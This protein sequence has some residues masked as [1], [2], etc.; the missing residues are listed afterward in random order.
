[1]QRKGYTK[2]VIRRTLRDA[3][4]AGIFTE[5]NIVVGVPGETNADAGEAIGFLLALKPY[6]RRV[7][8]I[9]PLM[10]FRGSDYWNDPE[11]FGIKFKTDKDYLYGTFPGAIP[12]WS[13]YSENPFIDSKVRFQRYKR[14][15]NQL[16]K[17]GFNL[18][19][20]VEFTPDEVQ[21]KNDELLRVS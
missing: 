2:D 5:V 13:W 8:F 3:W 17:N 4:E 9:N 21:K 20:W 6:I 14:I 1:M 19:E 7:P 15:Y 18:T 10:L 11:E 16:K 12:D